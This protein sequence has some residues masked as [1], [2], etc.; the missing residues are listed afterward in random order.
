V[1]LHD[2]GTCVTADYADA[3]H[4]DD[5]GHA[6]TGCEFDTPSLSGLASSPPYLHDGSAA[7]IREV[8]EKTRGKM[9]DITSLSAAELDELVEYLRSL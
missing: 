3:A 6:R 5:E 9:G 4:S 1:V 2:V 7:T 8:L